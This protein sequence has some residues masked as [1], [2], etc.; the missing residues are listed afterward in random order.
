MRLTGD[1]GSLQQFGGFFQGKKLE[2]GTNVVMLWRVE[3]QLELFVA[4][5]GASDFSQVRIDKC[6]ENLLSFNKGHFS[7]LLLPAILRRL[8]KQGMTGI[9][10]CLQAAICPSRVGAGVAL[11][12]WQCRRLMQQD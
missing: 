12:P 7:Y 5:P 11:L 2:K 9:H 3:G 10:L 1:I 4:A 8:L 6:Y